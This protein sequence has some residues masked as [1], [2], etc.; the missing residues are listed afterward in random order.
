MST[1]KLRPGADRRIRARHPWVFSNELAAMPKGHMSGSWVKLVDAKGHFV[2][3]G[4]GNTNSLIAFRALNFDDKIENPCD[5]EFI[6]AKVLAAWSQRQS[7]GYTQSFRLCYGEG[8]EIPG[9]VIDRYLVSSGASQYQVFA[10]QVL[11]AGIHRIIGESD[12]ILLRFFDRLVEEAVHHEWNQIPWSHTQVVV[13]NDVNVRR[14]EDLEVQEPRALKEIPGLDFANS[15]IHLADVEM[16]CDLLKGQKTGFF[17]DQAHNI[18]LVAEQIDR[19]LAGGIF[20]SGAEDQPVRILDLCSYVG[21]WSTRLT[22]RLRKKGRKVECTLVDVSEPALQFAKKN[23]ESVG[24]QAL[25]QKLD[26]LDGLGV[27]PDRHFDIVI[28]DPPAFIKSKKDVPTGRHAYL[29]L[30]SSAFRLVKRGGFVVSC[31]CSGLLTEADFMETLAKSIRRYPWQARCLVRGGHGADHPNS[32]AFPEGF[33]L[34]MF[35]HQV[36]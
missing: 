27:L 34:K 29:K 8:D 23:V 13:R 25:L 16:N 4:Y 33:Y 19:A 10:I 30:N 9:L 5:F 26:V 18:D 7:L 17:L 12:Q 21:Q 35:M 31:S 22:E 11:S 36:W 28:A 32:M 14:L 20:A 1:W 15:R 2:A 3:S 6:L 24:G